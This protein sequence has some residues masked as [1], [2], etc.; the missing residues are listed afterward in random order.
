MVKYDSYKHS[1]F[2]WMNQ[3]PNSWSLSRIRFVG[4]LYGGLTGKKGDDFNNDEN[5]KNKPFVPFTNIFNNTYISKNH[6]QYVNIEEGEKQ[7][8]VL[9]NDIFFL[10]SSETYEDLGKCSILLDDVDELYLNSFCKGYRIKDKRVFPL[11]LNYQLLG[12]LHKEMI[13]IEGNGFTRINLRQ[14]RLLDI[15]VFIPPLQEQNQ[16]VEFLDTKTTL[17]DTL[18]EKT[19]QKIELLKE[20][21]ISV[22]NQSIVQTQN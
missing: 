3:I 7:N 16:I 15:P 19:Q 10:M 12:S 20:Q 8:R 2:E 13:S 17:I 4:D 22:T 14:D 5:P 11:F 6:F 21:R 1:G 9:S 18:I